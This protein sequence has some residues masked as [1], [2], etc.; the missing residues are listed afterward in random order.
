M[1]GNTVVGIEVEVDKIVEVDHSLVGIEVG[2]EVVYNS[3]VVVDRILFVDPFLYFNK[4]KEE[5][6]AGCEIPLSYI[7]LNSY[8]HWLV[9]FNKNIFR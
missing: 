8:S 1:V 2:L 6:K 5:K 9:I 4:V 7:S 3:W